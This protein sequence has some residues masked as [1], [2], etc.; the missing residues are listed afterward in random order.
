ML[1]PM[2]CVVV[3]L[4]V[5]GVASSSEVGGDLE[6]TTPQSEIPQALE[7]LD[8]PPALEGPVSSVPK[9]TEKTTVEFQG[10]TSVQVNVD[11]EGMNISGD[12]ANEPSIAVDPL[13]PKRMAIGWRQ[14]DSVSSNFRQAGWGWSRDR[15]ASWT[16]PGVLTPGVFRSDPVLD[17]DGEGRFYYYSLRDRDSSSAISSSPTTAGRPG[18]GRNRRTAATSSGSPSTGP[19][20]PVGA[21]SM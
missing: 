2:A 19:T 18:P 17:A 8:D 6:P 10:F 1:R 15:G 20:A 21:T 12:A 14:F 3:V 13:D 7:Y 11:A 4:A 9:T 5:A 16:F